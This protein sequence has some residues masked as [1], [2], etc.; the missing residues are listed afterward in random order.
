MLIFQGLGLK[1]LSP[2]AT[3]QTYLRLLLRLLGL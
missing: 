3:E 2:E 1:V